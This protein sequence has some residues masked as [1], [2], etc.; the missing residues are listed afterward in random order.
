MPFVQSPG[1]P[2]PFVTS[3]HELRA[4][5]ILMGTRRLTAINLCYRQSAF[6]LVL[7]MYIKLF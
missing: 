7:P 2:W 4:R 5:F 1:S 6:L 3:Y